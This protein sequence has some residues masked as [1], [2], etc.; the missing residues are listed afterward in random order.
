VVNG[1]YGAALQT[2]YK[3]ALYRGYDAVGQIDGDG[4]HDPSCLPSLFDK[5]A[6]EGFDVVIG[7]R[8]LGPAAAYRVP[9]LRKIGMRFFRFLIRAFTGLRITDPTSGFQALSKRAFRFFARNDRFP[10]DYPDADVIVLLH[11]AGFRLTEVPVRMHADGGGK[12]IHSG[13]KPLYYVVKM[14]LSLFIV[15]VNRK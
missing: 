6:R 5:V 1:G 9:L 3:Y 13:F 10:S 8:F 4:Q 14:L 2:G 15:R 12:S 11:Y 7:S